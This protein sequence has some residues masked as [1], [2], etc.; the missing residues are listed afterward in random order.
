MVEGM[1]I[2][3]ALDRL[4]PPAGRVM[5]VHG[6][7]DATERTKPVPFTGWLGLLAALTEL[8]ELVEPPR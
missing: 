6:V 1:E 4:D 3:I 8:T 2:V 5:A 7:G